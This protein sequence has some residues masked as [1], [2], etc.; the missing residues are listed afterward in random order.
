MAKLINIDSNFNYAVKRAVEIFHSGRIFVYP[1]DTIY[2]FGCNPFNELAM[3][4]LNKLKGRSDEKKYILLINDVGNLLKY[5]NVSDDKIISFLN[6]IWPNPV[7]VVLN[8]NEKT[9]KILN[10]NS[11]AFRIPDN[12][13]CISLINKIKLPLVST[14][15]N[16]SNSPPLTEYSAIME[17]FGNKVDAIF[18]SEKLGIGEESI[19][20]DLRSNYPKILR[21]GKINIIELWEKLG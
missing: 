7:S 10:Y 15:V 3:Q 17:K 16:L 12:K 14:S 11:A 21:D 6:K 8:L 9:K 20:V 4:A 13:F 18:Y 5:V 1:T 2:G 19:V